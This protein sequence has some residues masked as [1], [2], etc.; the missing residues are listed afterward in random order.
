MLWIAAPRLS[1]ETPKVGLARRNRLSNIP[2]E[3][4]PAPL[5][6]HLDLANAPKM[7]DN[8]SRTLILIIST[9]GYLHHRSLCSDRSKPI[10]SVAG[11]YDINLTCLYARISEQPSL[12]WL[13]IWLHRSI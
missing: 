1:T 13:G 11:H 8:R 3:L 12:R 10:K 5:I 7:L 9:K 2:G 4:R 6:E